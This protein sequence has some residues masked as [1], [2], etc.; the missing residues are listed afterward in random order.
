MRELLNNCLFS[1]AIAVI[2]IAAAAPASDADAPLDSDVKEAVPK[3]RDQPR[4]P[5]CQGSASPILNKILRDNDCVP[6]APQHQPNRGKVF[7]NKH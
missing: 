3:D 7:S 1:S 6:Q 4:A 5:N 2:G